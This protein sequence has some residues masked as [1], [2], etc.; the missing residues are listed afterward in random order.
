MKRARREAPEGAELV[1]SPPPPALRHLRGQAVQQRP[2]RPGKQDEPEDHAEHLAVR[3]QQ[4]GL[5]RR[6]G[7]LAF[8]VG[9][10]RLAAPLQ[11]QGARALEIA[12]AQ[13]VEDVLERLHQLAEGDAG[14]QHRHGPDP[15][16]D[17]AQVMQQVEHDQRR[18]HPRADGGEPAHGA[19]RHFARIQVVGQAIEVAAEAGEHGVAPWQRTRPLDQQ[20]RDDGEEGHGV[21]GSAVD[22]AAIL[23]EP[24]ESG[25]R[26]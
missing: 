12:R 11:Q 17:R 21:S 9:A 6:L 1:V 24:D 2:G 23:N 5:D 3:A 22:G 13:R 15:A 4:R 19:V 16:E 8:A 26:S 7:D 25:A 20:R 14:V 18:Q 10:G